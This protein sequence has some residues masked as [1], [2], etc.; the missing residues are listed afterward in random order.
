MS[1]MSISPMITSICMNSTHE[2]IPLKHSVVCYR[3]QF[4]AKSSIGGV[5]M[6]E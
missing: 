1:E 5:N 3:S 2:S 4:Y 6:G